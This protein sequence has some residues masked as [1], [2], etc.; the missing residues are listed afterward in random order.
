MKKEKILE[1][2]RKDFPKQY[3]K[4]YEGLGYVSEPMP[5]LTI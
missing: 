1:Q 5:C 2:F 3:K 4:I